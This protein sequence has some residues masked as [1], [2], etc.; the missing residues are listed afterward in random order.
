MKGF[1][2][3]CVFSPL[4]KHKRIYRNG[5]KFTHCSLV[6]QAQRF[7]ETELAEALWCSQDFYH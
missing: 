2:V 6:F 5:W 3:V 7:A 4:G 1:Q